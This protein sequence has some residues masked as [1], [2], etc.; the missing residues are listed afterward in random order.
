[1]LYIFVRSKDRQNNVFS[2]MSYILEL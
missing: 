1:M 2:K